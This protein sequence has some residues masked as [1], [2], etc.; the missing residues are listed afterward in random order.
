MFYYQLSRTGSLKTKESK[1]NYF[2]MVHL[3]NLKKTTKIRNAY[4]IRVN[5]F[6]EWS[7]CS[8]N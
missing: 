6:N 2:G 8:Y 1:N 7:S 5:Y 4:T 3:H